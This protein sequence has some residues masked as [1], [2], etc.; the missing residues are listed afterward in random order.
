MR[1]QPKVYVVVRSDGE[2]FFV[3][4]EPLEGIQAWAKGQFVTVLEYDFRAVV[5]EKHP[6]VKS[7]PAPAAPAKAP[8]S[9][10]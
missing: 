10:S 7:E 4:K 6:P 3:E 9:L 8:V 1:V 2:R 5:Y